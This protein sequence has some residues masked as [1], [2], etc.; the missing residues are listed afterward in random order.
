M[1][2]IKK[3]AGKLQQRTKYEINFISLFSESPKMFVLFVV[4]VVF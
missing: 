4:V 2:F 1:D 3:K